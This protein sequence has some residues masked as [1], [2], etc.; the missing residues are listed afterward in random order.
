MWYIRLCGPA[1]LIFDLGFK[2][3]DVIVDLL[4]FLQSSS[5]PF[6]DVTANNKQLQKTSL[7]PKN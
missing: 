2:L 1:F 6:A 4:N 5:C 3:N 7:N